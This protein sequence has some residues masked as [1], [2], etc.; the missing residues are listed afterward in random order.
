MVAK[1]LVPDW[2]DIVDSGIGLLSYLP[3]RLYRQAG[4]YDNPMPESAIVRS[5]G[6]RIW[7]LDSIPSSDTGNRMGAVETM[8]KTVL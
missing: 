7:P 3:D 1:F 2:R 6:P 5:Y 8:L 4:R